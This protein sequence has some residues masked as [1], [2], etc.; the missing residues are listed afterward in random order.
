MPISEATIREALAHGTALS[1]PDA[2]YTWK[3]IEAR[4]AGRSRRIWLQRAAV[5]AA[6][7]AAVAI[8]SPM[9]RT[10]GADAFRLLLRVTIGQITYEVRNDPLLTF[11]INPDDVEESVTQLENGQEMRIFR[12]QLPGAD[13]AAVGTD[14]G[15]DRSP[16]GAGEA[17]PEA[18]LALS[19]RVIE[20]VTFRAG[21]GEVPAEALSAAAVP[22]PLPDPVPQVPLLL[23]VTVDAPT[24]GL[25][26][27]Q[28]VSF[29][30]ESPDLADWILITMRTKLVR[31]AVGEPWRS[32]LDLPDTQHISQDGARRAEAV[33]LNSQVSAI[34][35]EF[36]DRIAYYF[37]NGDQDIY[38]MGPA[39][40]ADLLR[41]MAESLAR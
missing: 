17:R 6:L 16:A 35:V 24:G 41:R 33:K 32:A 3:Q 40:Q 34:R 28:H 37:V 18:P 10:A 5:V 7:M 27:F 26:G 29:S 22:F 25:E 12:V 9:V 20:P 19:V 4:L 13:Q 36:H 38:V 11:K 31:S 14:A 15:T 30:W 8:T 2:G 21:P 1:V 39:A 23:H